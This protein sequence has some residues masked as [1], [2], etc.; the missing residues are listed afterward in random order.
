MLILW[1]VVYLFQLSG[2]VR[3]SL[4]CLERRC[5]A[6]NKLLVNSFC[7]IILTKP[8]PM[9]RFLLSLLWLIPAGLLAQSTL[10]KPLTPQELV[11]DIRQDIAD[12]DID[13]CPD[14]LAVVC[15]EVITG[16]TNSSTAGGA[17]AGTCGTTAGA[18]GNWYSFI[19][20]GDQIELSLC[21]SDYDTKIQVYSGACD[22]L[23]CEGG[24]D[25]SCGLQ[26][27]F[28]FTSVVGTE[29]F[30]YVFGFGTSTGNYELVV[31]C[32]NIPQ[33]CVDAAQI[34]CGDTVTGTTTGAP[35]DDTP[36]DL[37]GVADGTAGV[38]F[39]IAGTNELVPCSV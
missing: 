23:V 6:V 26:S 30:F 2:V 3:I 25:D 9:K 5:I 7:L 39:T 19:G 38:W 16:D 21:N 22:A 13:L 34:A 1:G 12:I 18:P 31:T 11:Q 14:A 27:E 4:Q 36:S 37:C 29:Y 20:T 15:G 24:N 35:E 17:P 28:A 33:G 8:T 10:E 32:S